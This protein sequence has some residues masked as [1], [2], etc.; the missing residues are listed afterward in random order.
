MLR[1][2]LGFFFWG[3]LLLCGA[4]LPLPLFTSFEVVIDLGVVIRLGLVFTLA[5]TH[6]AKREVIFH[7]LYHFHHF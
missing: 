6:L 7:A 1:S 4:L 2:S 5:L 3:S